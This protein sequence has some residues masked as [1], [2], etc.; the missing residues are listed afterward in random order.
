MKRNR[1]LV[2]SI[3]WVCTPI[4]LFSV[5]KLYGKLEGAYS[6]RKIIHVE[7]GDIIFRTNSYI[8]SGSKYYYKSGFPGHLSI[9]VS[10]GKFTN[11]DEKLGGIKVAESALFNRHK[12]KFQSDVAINKAFENFSKI[13]GKRFLLKMHLNSEQKQRLIELTGKQIGRPYSIL[14][15]KNGQARFNCATFV[16]WAILEVTRFDLDIDGGR[17]VFPNDILKSSRF[18]NPGDRIRF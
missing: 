2:L 10:E 8:L 5:D 17:I 7:V 12:V 13:K 9:A 6:E 4:V 1:W 14:A 11:T 15:P 18:D 16:R 3:V